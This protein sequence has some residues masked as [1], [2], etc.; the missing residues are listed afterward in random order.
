MVLVGGILRFA[1]VAA[2]SCSQMGSAF[3]FSQTGSVASHLG[4]LRQSFFRPYSAALGRES[5]PDQ[6]IGPSSSASRLLPEA[7]HDVLRCGILGALTRE[8]RLLFSCSHRRSKSS[9]SGHECA[10]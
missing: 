5:S 6:A 4:I 9:L 1:E 7:R 2:S 8:C 10:C 3:D